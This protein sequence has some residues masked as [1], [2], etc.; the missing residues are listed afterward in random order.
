MSEAF[1]SSRVSYTSMHPSSGELPM[2]VDGSHFHAPYYGVLYAIKL[3]SPAL[4]SR[5]CQNEFQLERFE[6]GRVPGPATH[7]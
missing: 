3:M 6:N 2:S 5:A 1:G 4:A 7:I